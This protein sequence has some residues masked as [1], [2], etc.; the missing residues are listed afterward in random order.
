MSWQVKISD[1]ATVTDTVNLIRKTVLEYAHSP[2][3]SRLVVKLKRESQTD[4]Q[5][6]KKLF[7]FACRNVEYK[8]DEPGHEKVTTPER[9]LRDGVGDCKKFTTLIGAALVNAGYKPLLKI[10]SYNNKTWAHIYIIVPVK[11]DRKYIVLD[12]V[13]KCQYDKEVDHKKGWLHNLNGESMELSLLGK[14][15]KNTANTWKKQMFQ[16]LRNNPQFIRMCANNYRSFQRLKDAGGLKN[17]SATSVAGDLLNQMSEISGEP[18]T[19]IMGEYAELLGAEDYSNSLL[20]LSGA[21]EYQFQSLLGYAPDSLAAEELLFGVYGSD[22]LGRRKKGAKKKR[23]GKVWGFLKKVGLAPSRIAFLGMV[24][25]N[26]FGL[27]KKLYLSIKKDKGAR[28]KK[29]W[30][31]LGG[32]WKK[33]LKAINGGVKRLKRKGKLKGLNEFEASLQGVSGLGAAPLAAIAAIAVPIITAVLSLFKKQG[34]VNKENPEDV[35][36]VQKV[37]QAEAQLE[38]KIDNGQ[39]QQIVE[40]VQADP[41]VQTALANEAAQPQAAEVASSYESDQEKA[42]MDLSGLGAVDWGNLLNTVSSVVKAVKPAVKP[43]VAAI[44]GIKQAAKAAKNPQTKAYLNNQASKA[45]VALQQATAPGASGIKKKTAGQQVV[46]ILNDVSE[47]INGSLNTPLQKNVGSFAGGTFT[48]KLLKVGALVGTVQTFYGDQ[49]L[50][51]LTNL[52]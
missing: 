25:I 12:P 4:E 24:R 44:K 45:T 50:N 21:E 10:V 33:L 7:A 6:F 46:S 42:N 11:G 15:D 47:T 49:I 35:A 34:V 17:I 8:R 16:N 1:N 37:D 22:D 40:T 29:L 36:M 5:F 31:K 52:F 38:Q 3:V 2:V 32:N 20:G 14:L 30:K 27:A 39:A 43:A 18:V 26:L 28:L 51:F 41:R 13:N 48:H 9:L 23:K 19:E